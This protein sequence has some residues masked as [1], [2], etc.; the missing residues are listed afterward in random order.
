MRA[1]ILPG[2]HCGNLSGLA[3]FS[4]LRMPQTAGAAAIFFIAWQRTSNQF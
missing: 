3:V 2:Q 1:P 4:R